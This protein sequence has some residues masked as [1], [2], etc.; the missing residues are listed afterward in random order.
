MVSI[1]KEVWDKSD[2]I[3]K[4]KSENNMKLLFKKNDLSETKAS[5]LWFY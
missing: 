5:N 2:E 4:V 1:P 3:F